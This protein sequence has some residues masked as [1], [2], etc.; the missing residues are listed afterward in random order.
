MGKRLLKPKKAVQIDQ[1]N[2]NQKKEEKMKMMTGNLVNHLYKGRILK[3]ALALA[4]ATLAC[5]INVKLPLTRI[6]TG[7]T[8]TADIQVP[9]PAQPSG[10]V[11]LSLEFVAGELK[12]APGASGALA[13]GA[14]T[15]NAADLAPKIETTGSSTTLRSG[16]LEIEGLPRVDEKLVNEWDLKLADTPLSLE[17][18]AGAYT[19]SFELGGLSLEKLAISEGGSDTKVAFSTPNQVEMESF[20][21]STGAS[22]TELRGLANANFTQ[23]TFHSGAGD[24]TLSFDGDLQRDASVAIDAGVG[25]VTILVPQGVQAQVTFD[26]GLASVD[27]SGGWAQDGK[28]YILS[29]SGPSLTI[30]VKMGAGNLKLKT[31]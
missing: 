16:D 25:T 23:M 12:L 4:L 28:V 30:T 11:E 24:A 9:L 5:G 15:F 7:P 2:L 18:Q 8:Q 20:A 17:I 6:K 3:V 27:A 13:A 19:G 21:Y 29:G 22:N 10:V 14:A 31:K 26:G 1:S